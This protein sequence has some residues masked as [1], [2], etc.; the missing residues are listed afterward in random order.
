MQETVAVID[1]EDDTL[2][3]PSLHQCLVAELGH[4]LLDLN[5]IPIPNKVEL[6]F[7]GFVNWGHRGMNEEKI[8]RT[9]RPKQDLNFFS[10]VSGL[11]QMPL[12]SFFNRAPNLLRLVVL[13]PRPIQA[14]GTLLGIVN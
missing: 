10:L 4:A 9:K 3:D 13:T 2:P 8:Y 14:D 12:P 7:W 11:P 5:R 6:F 1:L